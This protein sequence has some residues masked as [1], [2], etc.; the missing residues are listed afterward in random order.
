M[1]I[2]VEILGR[3]EGRLMKLDVEARDSLD[4]VKAMI[5]F[6]KAIPPGHQKF[7]FRGTVLE[8]SRPVS[9]YNI[10]QGSKLSL[11]IKRPDDLSTRLGCHYCYLPSSPIDCDNGGCLCCESGLGL[12]S[13]E[14]ILT[15]K[16]SNNIEQTSMNKRNSSFII[17]RSSSASAPSLAYTVLRS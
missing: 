3:P 8:G 5:N 17:T 1:Q 15:S 6:E 10:Q 16:G 4:G 14:V 7:I 12:L 2:F 9:E 11:A 13:H